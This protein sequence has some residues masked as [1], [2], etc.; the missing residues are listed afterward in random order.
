M[1]QQIANEKHGIMREAVREFFDPARDF[2][3]LKVAQ[4]AI[5]IA[6]LLLRVLHQIVDLLRSKTDTPEHALLSLARKR[7]IKHVER[8]RV[9]ERLEFLLHACFD[10]THRLRKHLDQCSGPAALFRERR[11]ITIDVLVTIL[12]ML[13]RKLPN[14]SVIEDRATREQVVAVP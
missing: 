2:A 3:I 11:R 1:A 7:F 14:R 8:L 13:G 12:V 6:N 5:E 9:L 10:E 4:S